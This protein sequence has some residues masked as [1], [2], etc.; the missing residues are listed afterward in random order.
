MSHGTTAFGGGAAPFSFSFAA[1]AAAC[2]SLPRCVKRWVV[3]DLTGK[4][5]GKT[6][7]A[8][9]A[10]QFMAAQ[11]GMFTLSCELEFINADADDQAPQQMTG[12]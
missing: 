1:P 2:G 9:E 6:E 4:V 8:D 11:P 5:I 10:T 12:R 7:R 3:K